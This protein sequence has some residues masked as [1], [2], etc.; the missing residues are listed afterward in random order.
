M[1]S[2][3]TCYDCEKFGTECEGTLPP[4]EHRNAVENYCDKF[5]LISW[6]RDMF[7]ESGTKR[8]GV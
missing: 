3:Y 1:V 5:V 2:M 8:L 4:E 7:K 6:R